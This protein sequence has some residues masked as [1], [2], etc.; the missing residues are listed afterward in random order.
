MYRQS[1]INFIQTLPIE[2]TGCNLIKAIG[3]KPAIII[4]NIMLDIAQFM[5]YRFKTFWE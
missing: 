1:L 2:V 5:T 4:I 3:T